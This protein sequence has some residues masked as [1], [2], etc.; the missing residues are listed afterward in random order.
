M[1]NNFA[2]WLSVGERNF[3]AKRRGTWVDSS[4][5][6]TAEQT[7][8]QHKIAA[9]FAKETKKKSHA[10]FPALLLSYTSCRML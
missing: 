6:H 1:T 3:N 4:T 8:H 9:Q 10:C 5:T 2:L 7:T